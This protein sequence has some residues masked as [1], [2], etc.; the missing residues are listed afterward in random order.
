[1]TEFQELAQLLFGNITKTPQAMEDHTKP[2]KP[3]T[4][5]FM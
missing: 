1:M 5:F 4:V 2:Q 3:L